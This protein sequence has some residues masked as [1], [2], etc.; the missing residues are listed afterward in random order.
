LHAAG[1]ERR[2]INGVVVISIRFLTAYIRRLAIRLLDLAATAS[3]FHFLACLLRLADRNCRPV[4]RL[5]DPAAAAFLM[6]RDGNVWLT[7][8]LRPGMFV[9]WL[10]GFATAAA[11]QRLDLNV[12][13][14]APWWR[15][16]RSPLG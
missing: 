9:S 11:L 7:A 2:V 14:A 8:L 3:F 1:T 10:L 13:L 5:L 4:F 6:R 16:N 15:S 12:R